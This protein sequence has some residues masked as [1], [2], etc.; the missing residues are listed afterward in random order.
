MKSNKLVKNIKS[1]FQSI[2]VK[3]FVTLAATVIIIIGSLLIV[4]TVVLETYYIYSKQTMLLG[5]YNAI[6]NY[7]N[8]ENIN[9]NIE[10][11]LE[12]LSQRNDFDI[13]IKTNNSLYA[14][15]RDFLSSLVDAKRNENKGVNENLLYSS[16]NV[17]IKKTI[18]SQTELSYILLS[19]KLDNGYS[20]YIRAAVASIQ[21]SA[22]IANRCLMIIGVFAIM[23]SG[24]I[25]LVI[26]K[27]FTSPIEELNK[28]TKKI[29]E[30]DF[31][32]KY[33]INDSED[34]INN[35]R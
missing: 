14:S 23:L 15:S 33:R 21:E 20:L 17:E 19:A 5:A 29:S 16:D 18:D 34:E 27:R 28:I 6:N 13:L 12:K 25:V 10:I 1:K 2:K 30:L 7:Y 31:S 11:E 4:N 22:K 24:I 3:L 35:L 9:T 8:E 32:H 26:S